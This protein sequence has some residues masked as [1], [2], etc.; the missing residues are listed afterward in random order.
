M[1]ACLVIDPLSTLSKPEC[2]DTLQK[3]CI[4]HIQMVNICDLSK[5]RLKHFPE[6]VTF[7]EEEARVYKF[8]DC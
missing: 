6:D 4:G 5:Y 3:I 2:F 7:R 8:Y 1:S